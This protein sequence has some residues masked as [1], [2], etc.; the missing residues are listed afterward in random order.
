MPDAPEIEVATLAKNSRE[1]IRIRLNEY[2]GAYYAD[3]RVFMPFG[4]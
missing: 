1:Q 2:R 4:G 3:V